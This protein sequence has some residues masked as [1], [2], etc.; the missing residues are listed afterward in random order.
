[1]LTAK[2]I[3]NS[4]WLWKRRISF[5]GSAGSL[6]V[7]LCASLIAGTRTSADPTR[8]GSALDGLVQSHD[9]PKDITSVGDDIQPRNEI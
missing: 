9:P 1:M 3:S 4:T 2:M 6:C 5:A 7:S 8:H